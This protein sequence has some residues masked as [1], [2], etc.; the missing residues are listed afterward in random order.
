MEKS[1]F[2]LPTHGTTSTWRLAGKLLLK[3]IIDQRFV[4]P[5]FPPFFF[6][7]LLNPK[8]SL[9]L[10][11]LEQFDPVLAHQLR[12]LQA[13]PASVDGLDL[14]FDRPARPHTSD[15]DDD[16]DD[17]GDDDD[18]DDDTSYGSSYYDSSSSSDDKEEEEDSVEEEDTPTEVTA[19]NV[20][21][22][23]AMR[24][25][26]T[27]LGN[28]R[29]KKIDSVREGL[30]SVDSL[31]ANLR[32]MSGFDFCS[33]L[34]GNDTSNPADLLPFINFD[35]SVFPEHIRRYL[36]ECSQ[37]DSHRL[38]W[39][40][41]GFTALPLPEGKLICFH[42]N[43]SL[44]QGSL[45]RAHTCSFVVELPDYPNYDIFAEKLTTAIKNSSESLLLA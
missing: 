18:D 12:S 21:R 10:S 1:P 9:Q 22:Y 32:L 43:P 45:P 16:D 36:S 38:L 34:K 2:V 13:F 7:L 26:S 11:D 37:E 23:V 25:T 41:T 14:T 3:A 28:G 17:D 30:F 27:L 40:A 44:A 29:K 15:D 24:V 31:K 4:Q 42:L 39:F 33:L 5:K 19:E 8:R 35:E 6:E 20:H